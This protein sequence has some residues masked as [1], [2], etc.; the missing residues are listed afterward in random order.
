MARIEIKS[1]F[2]GETIAYFGDTA[3]EKNICTKALSKVDIRQIIQD[4]DNKIVYVSA[5]V[6]PIEE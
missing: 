2:T 4:G 1:S 6:L 5:I 3:K